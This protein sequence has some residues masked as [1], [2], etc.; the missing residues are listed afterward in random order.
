MALPRGSRAITQG[1]FSQWLTRIYNLPQRI[2]TS[3]MHETQSSS[4]PHSRQWAIALSGGVDS[5]A[6]AT[7]LSRHVQLNATS[8][9][10]VS[11]HAM[12]VNH[13]LRDNSREEA[14]YVAS[15][16][17]RLGLQPHVL[18]LDWKTSMESLANQRLGKP[19]KV[20]LETLARIK[21]YN[22]IAHRCAE[23]SIR[24]LLEATCRAAGTDWVEDPTNSSLDYQRNIIR[25]YQKELDRTAEHEPSLTA[26]TTHSLLAFRERMDRHR[27]A[28]YSQVSPWLSRIEFDKENG[29]CFFQLHQSTTTGAPCSSPVPWL[30]A[31]QEHIGNRLLAQL[32]R[33]VTCKDHV[34]RSEDI[35]ELLQKLRQAVRTESSLDNFN[36]NNNNNNNKAQHLMDSSEPKVET[37]SAPTTDRHQNPRYRKKVSAANPNTKQPA[38]INHAGVLILPPRSSK[39]ASTLY[40]TLSR[41][42][43][44]TAEQLAANVDVRLASESNKEPT[45]ILWNN[46][47]HMSIQRLWDSKNESLLQVRLLHEADLQVLR[48]KK[49]K[50]KM[51]EEQS[52]AATTNSALAGGDGGSKG[53][54]SALLEA[55]L[56]RVPNKARYLIPVVVDKSQGTILSVPSIGIHLQPQ[57]YLIQSRYRYNA[58]I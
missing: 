21:R 42:P 25:H 3:C 38:S 16:A 49:N 34:P 54:E 14:E 33:W 19:D 50:E 31:S 27:R 12:I 26:L 44:T 37:K 9:V 8:G 32:V 57:N 30:S 47:F 7:L 43:Y 1:E 41:Q 51:E 56:E 18:H 15:L 52:S 45:E 6:L 17:S 53:K 29:C 36:N 28:A 10:P 2:T 5:M 23:L 13:D 58:P 35:Q 22:A 48:M 20:H 24:H 40:W 4:L 46:R 39:N 11:I 55:Y